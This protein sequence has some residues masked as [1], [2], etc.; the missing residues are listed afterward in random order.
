MQRMHRVQAVRREAAARTMAML[1]QDASVIHSGNKTA[2]GREKERESF[3][4]N[5]VRNGGVSGATRRQALQAP[6][7][8][9]T[10]VLAQRQPGSQTNHKA[11][12][13]IAPQLSTKAKLSAPG[14]V[15]RPHTVPL[16]SAWE[17]APGKSTCWERH[18]PK[19]K[20]GA[21]EEDVLRFRPEQAEIEELC[22]VLTDKMY[23]EK[24]PEREF[25]KGVRFQDMQD[26][27]TSPD[28]YF[29]QVTFYL[30]FVKS[31][32][33][34]KLFADAAAE[35]YEDLSDL[36]QRFRKFKCGKDIALKDW[37]SPVDDVEEDTLY[38]YDEMIWNG[39]LRQLIGAHE[40]RL[41]TA[42]ENRTEA[43]VNLA[44]KY[45]AGATLLD[46]LMPE[47]VATSRTRSTCIARKGEK[48][49]SSINT[50]GP[51]HSERLASIGISKFSS[52]YRRPPNDEEEEE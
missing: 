49:H 20:E 17:P 31:S 41:V 46:T 43:I 39:R 16:F 21:A 40:A 18:K 7:H 12:A 9:R 19:N 24:I 26:I 27:M 51:K 6:A 11:T 36:H 47:R 22:A 23:W 48:S 5:N 42:E 38:L 10:A 45:V 29:K 1:E 4:R 52:A 33:N 25:A 2:L 13:R 15:S 14:R 50:G 32:A 3:L 8:G 30:P 34:L 37:N 35:G 44:M 28:D